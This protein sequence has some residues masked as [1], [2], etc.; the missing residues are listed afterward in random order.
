MIVAIRKEGIQGARRPRRKNRVA[1]W[2]KTPKIHIFTH[3][4]MSVSLDETDNDD[5][6]DELVKWDGARILEY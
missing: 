6:D 1:R 4:R 2:W 5:N 3:S